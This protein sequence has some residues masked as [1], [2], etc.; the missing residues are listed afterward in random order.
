MILQSIGTEQALGSSVSRAAESEND[1]VMRQAG[2][3][4]L[5]S[6]PVCETDLGLESRKQRRESPT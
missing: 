6:I 5:S 3:G 1:E 2:P 4:I